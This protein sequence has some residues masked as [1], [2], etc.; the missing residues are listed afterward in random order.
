MRTWKVL[1]KSFKISKLQKYAKEFKSSPKNDCSRAKQLEFWKIFAQQYFSAKSFLGQNFSI[2]VFV[3]GARFL[4]EEMGK[5]NGHSFSQ[6]VSEAE[7]S[8]P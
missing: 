6:N 8:N 5:G 7:K 2:F 3:G 4:I 1:E